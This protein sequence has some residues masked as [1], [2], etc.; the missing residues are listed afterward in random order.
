MPRSIIPITMFLLMAGVAGAIE[1]KEI[2]GYQLMSPLERAEYK[3]EMRS[4][5]TEADRQDYLQEHH[6]E[7]DERAHEEGVEL[8][9]GVIRK[10]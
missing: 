8:V 5:K 1:T 7:M 6:E 9:D 3:A 10:P 2:Y 4:L